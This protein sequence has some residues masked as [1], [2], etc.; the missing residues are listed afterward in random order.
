[1]ENL[2]EAGAQG[3]FS[4]RFIN[5][6][7]F[8]LC[9]DWV[10]SQ[11]PGTLLLTGLIKSGH[12]YIIPSIIECGMKLLIHSQTSTVKPLKFGNGYVISSHILLGMWLII[13]NG[14]K[15]NP[16]FRRHN[17]AE[18][19]AEN[20]ANGSSSTRPS[21]RYRKYHILSSPLNNS[22]TG[23]TGEYLDIKV[24]SKQYK[25]YHYKDKMVS[26]SSLLYWESPHAERGSLYWNGLQDL[27]IITR[28]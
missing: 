27:N 6:A 4:V 21:C 23:N 8:L 28:F 19:Q 10:S 5:V 16:C 12:E 18:K 2:S 7:V 22:Y 25:Y 9:C 20:S 13:H 26:R 17:T 1:M 11:P 3:S 15:V 14:I 24:P